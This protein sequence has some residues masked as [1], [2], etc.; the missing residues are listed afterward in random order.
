MNYDSKHYSCFVFVCSVL[1]VQLNGTQKS[2]THQNQ[3]QSIRMATSSPDSNGLGN[4]NDNLHVDD[5]QLEENLQ[6]EKLVPK[7]QDAIETLI[8]CK[9]YTSAESV[10]AFEFLSTLCPTATIRRRLADEVVKLEGGRLFPLV[11]K[12]LKDASDASKGDEHQTFFLTILRMMKAF[13]ANFTDASPQLCQQ[14]GQY[15]AFKLLF[16]EFSTYYQVVEELEDEMKKDQFNTSLVILHNC[17]RQWNDNK[18][19]YRKAD[20]VELLT[21]YVRSNHPLANKTKCLLTLSYIVN[22][23]ENGNLATQNCCVTHLLDLLKKAVA[24][25]DHRIDDGDAE[26]SVAEL[27][28]GVYRI[29]AND[30]NKVCCMKQEQIGLFK[31]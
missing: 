17:I 6:L 4:N 7:V 9:D 2:H 13:F 31:T 25:P 19:L 26:F 11:W 18:A 15:E 3:H 23:E 21:K 29:A 1:Q 12:Q 16:E 27:L 30:A 24:T 14:L 5:A 8:D 20:A 28:D 22:E 10:D